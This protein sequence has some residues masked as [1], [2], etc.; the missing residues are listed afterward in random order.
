MRPRIEIAEVVSFRLALAQQA[1]ERL[2]EELS[3]E[4]KLSLDPDGTDLVLQHVEGDSSLR[5]ARAGDE[6]ALTEILVCNDEA[7]RFFSRVLGRLMTDHRGDLEIKVVWN[8]PERNT[9]GS[10]A[11]VELISGKTKPVSAARALRNTLVAGAQ[12]AE[13]QPAGQTA[14]GTPGPTAKDREEEEVARL[15]EKGRIAWAEYQRLK[16]ARK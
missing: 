1:L 8:V 2:V 6:L 10:H 14:A 11:T 13:L 4:M 16:A 15:L 3:G 7:G 12:V 9:E 5:F